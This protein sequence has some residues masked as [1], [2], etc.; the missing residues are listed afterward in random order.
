MSRGGRHHD[1]DLGNGLAPRGGFFPQVT[2]GALAQAPKV[3][4]SSEPHIPKI[5]GNLTSGV[6]NPH[7]CHGECSLV[8]EDPGALASGCLRLFEVPGAPVVVG[9]L[10]VN[11]CGG[12]CK[13]AVVP[14]CA[15]K[16]ACFLSRWLWGRGH[17]WVPA[18]TCSCC[19]W[20]K[21]GEVVLEHD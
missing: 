20:R 2:V 4:P 12:G 13:R 18:C 21:E 5:R 15:G 8:A 16:A 11:V 17:L 1:L 7:T 3:S 10:C 14:V 6:G 9:N 19:A